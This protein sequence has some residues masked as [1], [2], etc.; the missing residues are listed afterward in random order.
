MTVRPP[1]VAGSFYPAAAAQLEAQLAHLLGAV[2]APQGPCPKALIVPHAG[3]IYSGPIAASA[4]ARIAPHGEQLE[5]V[6]LV[7]PAH[8]M[9]VAGLA[10]TGAD[11][12]RTPLGDVEVEQVDVPANTAAHAREHSLE[13]QI[14][15]L[16]A[17]AGKFQ[18]SAI[19]VGT[20]DFHAL[21]D[22]GHALARAIRSCG[23]PVLIV[24]SSDMNHYESAEVNKR[25]DDLAIEQM[26][27]LNA[28]GLHRVVIEKDIGMCGFA[29]AVAALVA[30]RDMG[31]HQG[32]LVRYAHSGE[33]TGDSDRVVS[34]AGML[35][36]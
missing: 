30:C 28:E 16:Q 32:R 10:A 14:P 20:A 9:F 12:L 19:C 4:F 11:R 34:Y 35:I 1:A 18:F 22:L 5:R 2:Q 24:V 31:A 15:F 3:Y 33:V 36:E 7:G 21:A 8:R 23:E 13:V 17:A 27:A 25:K 29:P 26:S 6:V